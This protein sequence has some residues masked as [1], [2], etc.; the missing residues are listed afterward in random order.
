MI[1][2]HC[3]ALHIFVGRCC[4]RLI[5]NDKQYRQKCWYVDV[6]T[7]GSLPKCVSPKILEMYVRIQPKI[8]NQTLKI[9]N[10][11][12][13]QIFESKHAELAHGDLWRWQGV[14]GDVH[15]LDAKIPWNTGLWSEI[16]DHPGCPVLCFV[17]PSSSWPEFF[18]GKDVP[19]WGKPLK[20][21][22]LTCGLP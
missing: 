18:Q 7:G 6:G 3:R 2:Y 20:Q 13:D 21:N 4:L 8:T 10:Q 12:T 14:D 15:D 11:T 22:S 17:S 5:V 16:L 1:A 19:P 9:T